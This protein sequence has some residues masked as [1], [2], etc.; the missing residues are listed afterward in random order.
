MKQH[1][2]KTRVEKEETRGTGR[3]Q[4]SQANLESGCL[5]AGLGD[6]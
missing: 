6:C 2:G 5:V 3:R 1:E 4:L